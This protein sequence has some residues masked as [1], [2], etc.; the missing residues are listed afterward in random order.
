MKKMFLAFAVLASSIAFAANPK[1]DEKIEK[2]F[3]ESF[4]RAEKVT[5]Y[6]GNGYYEV[7]FTNNQVNCRLWYDESGNVT[8][9]E[10]YYTQESLSPFLLAKINKNLPVKKYLA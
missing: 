1:P 5:W 6:E 2:R 3:K 9:T 7:I 4:P 10:R 8:K